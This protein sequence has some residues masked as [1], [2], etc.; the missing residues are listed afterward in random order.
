MQSAWKDPVVEETRE[1]GRAYTQRLGGDIH[2]IFEDLRCHQSE[3]PER[4]V[5]QVTVVSQ[6]P[7]RTSMS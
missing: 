6:D 5:T 1:R 7:Q 4:Y 3:R 2:R